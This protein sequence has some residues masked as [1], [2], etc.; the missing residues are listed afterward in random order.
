MNP[1]F[2]LKHFL[3]KTLLLLPLC[4]GIWYLTAALWIWPVAICAD[5]LLPLLFP[6]LVAGVEQAGHN[7]NIVTH[8]GDIQIFT[9]QHK[10]A[11][12]EFSLNPRAYGYSLALYSAILLA[13]PSALVSHKFKRWCLGILML[14]GILLFGVCT[15]TLKSIA[16]D[17]APPG[18]SYPTG[19]SSTQL[20]VLGLSYQLGYLILPAIVP[21]LL[22]AVANQKLFV[23]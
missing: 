2:S 10:M 7:L 9:E 16:F 17:L 1:L 3:G 5:S 19:F 4:F 8:L 14:T 15:D 11:A 23:K 13:S 12:L 18:M 20:N 22:W 6:H 21:L